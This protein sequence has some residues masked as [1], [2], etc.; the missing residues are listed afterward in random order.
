MWYLAEIVFAQPQS[1]NRCMY[2]CES[3]NVLLQA[4][5]AEESYR[6]ALDWG[7][8]YIAD[9]SEKMTLLGIANLTQIG[10]AIGDGVEVC[11]CYFKKLDIW[12]RKDELIPSK[13]QLKAI[14][15]KAE[16]STPIQEMIDPYQLKILK[17]SI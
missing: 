9:S 4:T 8:N 13:E 3:C 10:D 16:S 6:K 11:G 14:R 15:W 17:N 12:N 5:S 2:L 1:E 7:H